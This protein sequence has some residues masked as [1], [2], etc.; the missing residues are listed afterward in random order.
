MEMKDATF[1]LAKVAVVRVPDSSWM[2]WFPE[3]VY[4]FT[5]GSSPIEAMSSVQ[6]TIFIGVWQVHWF[7]EHQ[8]KL[9]FIK[10]RG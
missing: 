2:L 3:L 9:L 1:K 7:H 10:F 4:L 8:L 5:D 6:L